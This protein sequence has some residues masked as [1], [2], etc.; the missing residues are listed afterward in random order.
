MYLAETE[1]VYMP[2]INFAMQQNHVP[3]IKKFSTKNISNKDLENVTISIQ[4]NPDFLLPYQHRIDII[5]Q[6]EV[7]EVSFLNL[8]L[9]PKFL[10]ELTERISGN[11]TLTICE[12][13]EQ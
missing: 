3:I 1:F 6:D 13:E 4:S 2:V 12:G 7:I 11:I 10:A 5:K 8:K 9:S